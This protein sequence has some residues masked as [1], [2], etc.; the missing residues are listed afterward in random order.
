MVFTV[1]PP[2]QLQYVGTL[3]LTHMLRLAFDFT[4]V[5]NLQMLM[6][7]SIVAFARGKTALMVASSQANIEAMRVLLAAG[8]GDRWYKH[9]TKRQRITQAS[10]SK[11]SKTMSLPL[12][13]VQGEWV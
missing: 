10:Y 9:S 5:P 2:S 13:R 12:G 3:C 8:A 11:Y 4:F 6:Q 1:S 7:C